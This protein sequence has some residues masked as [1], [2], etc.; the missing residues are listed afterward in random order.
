[1]ETAIVISIISSLTAIIVAVLSIIFN[2]R[3]Q[4]KTSF[5]LERL[6]MSI[7]LE[8]KQIE[9]NVKQKDETLNYIDLALESSQKIKDNI[10]LLTN[11]L[12]FNSNL[13][14]EWLEKNRQEILD[15]SE[16]FSK[17]FPK[18]GDT[19]KA[20]LHDMKKELY[21]VDFAIAKI[22]YEKKQNKEFDI[23]NLS[24][25]LLVTRERLNELQHSL[26][27]RKSAY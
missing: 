21:Q 9:E 25:S 14:D 1:M 2:S 6:K 24:N 19:E 20:L 18:L 16:L 13:T 4:K 26:L 10:Q 8:K 27:V 23:N 3:N 5:E 7:E 15:Y 12:K 22:L 17:I 11:Y